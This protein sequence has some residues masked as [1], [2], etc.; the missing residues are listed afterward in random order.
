MVLPF[1][2]CHESR[3][4][5]TGAVGKSTASAVETTKRDRY[6]R[7]KTETLPNVRI[8]FPAPLVLENSLLI[9]EKA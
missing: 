8:A 4:N 2:C 6:G 7:I 5:S 3:H 1:R 9:V